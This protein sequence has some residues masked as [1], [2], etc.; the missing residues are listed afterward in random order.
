MKKIKPTNSNILIEVTIEAKVGE[1]HIPEE[2]R[3][4]GMKGEI[5]GK[6]LAVGPKALHVKEGHRVLFYK[7]KFTSYD[8]QK[9]KMEGEG[10]VWGVLLREEDL[11]AILE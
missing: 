2:S 10:D 1:I 3:K 5:E 7:H 8:A 4:A 6:V 9:F 11:I